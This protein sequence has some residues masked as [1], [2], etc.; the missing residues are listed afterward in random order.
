MRVQEGN[1]HVYDYL[2]RKCKTLYLKHVFDMMEQ[3][4]S[5]WRGVLI[6]GTGILA[7]S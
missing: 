6:P 2:R 3:N 5:G 1:K 7:G 4:L